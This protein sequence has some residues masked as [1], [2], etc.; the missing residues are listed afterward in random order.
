LA[1]RRVA[2]R[3]LGVARTGCRS[4]SRPW[5][6]QCG[7]VGIRLGLG[8]RLGCS[9]LEL[10]FLWRLHEMASSLDRLGMARRP[11]ERLLVRPGETGGEASALTALLV[12]GMLWHPM[13]DR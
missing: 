8:T 9:G 1:R 12:A 7:C 3:R 10:C 6:R 5:A 11:R 2:W 13:R 4:R